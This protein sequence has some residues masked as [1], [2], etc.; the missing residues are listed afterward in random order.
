MEDTDLGLRASEE[1]LPNLKEHIDLINYNTALQKRLNST[2]ARLHSL[3]SNRDG[4]LE[5]RDEYWR[6]CKETNTRYSEKALDSAT[7]ASNLTDSCVSLITTVDTMSS[8]IRPVDKVDFALTKPHNT[9]NFYKKRMDRTSR[10][11]SALVKQ[12]LNSL[13]EISDLHRSISKIEVTTTKHLSFEDE[14][15][16]IPERPVSI[17][18]EAAE[19]SYDRTGW[20]ISQTITDESQKEE[21]TPEE[22]AE[23]EANDF[24]QFE[25]RVIVFCE[26]FDCSLEERVNMMNSILQTPHLL[27]KIKEKYIFDIIERV[28]EYSFGHCTVTEFFKHFAPLFNTSQFTSKLL[29]SNS[30][31]FRFPDLFR[32][33]LVQ[34][35][36]M[37][38]EWCMLIFTIMT[39]E[40]KHKDFIISVLMSFDAI[41]ELEGSMIT[42]FSMVF[43]QLVRLVDQ[44]DAFLPLYRFPLVIKHKELV[45]MILEQQFSRMNDPKDYNETVSSTL[46]ECIPEEYFQQLEKYINVYVPIE[47]YSLSELLSISSDVYIQNDFDYAMYFNT[48]D[49]RLEDTTAV[50]EFLTDVQSIS[51]FAI[52]I[53]LLRQFVDKQINEFGTVSLALTLLHGLLRDNRTKRDILRLLFD[54]NHRKYFLDL[55][56]IADEFIV[57]F[58]E[59]EGIKKFFGHLL[60]IFLLTNHQSNLRNT[61][62]ATKNPVEQKIFVRFAKL[63]RFCLLNNINT[64]VTSIT[65]IL[66]GYTMEV[67]LMKDAFEDCNVFNEIRFMDQT[68]ETKQFITLIIDKY[69]NHL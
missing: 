42:Q 23:A 4:V 52:F 39:D 15:E 31:I 40:E 59:V 49:D 1:S 8:V 68:D 24:A 62:A 57:T 32:M 16:P 54:N 45:P 22:K 20:D 41:K 21:Q 35:P 38:L 69:D 25:N 55:I 29:E 34:N 46:K 19:P 66:I 64:H 51:V 67:P 26:K 13:D 30:F 48:L 60:E 18:K 27:D 9:L 37:G 33:L 61:I 28:F 36:Q 43:M 63:L 10:A 65:L 5:Q 44:F 11:I 47:D 3:S 12:S 56:L 53:R 14:T 17:E 50:Q 2:V 7:I 58:Q 6:V